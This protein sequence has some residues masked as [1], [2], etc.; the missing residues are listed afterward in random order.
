MLQVPSR[1]YSHIRLVV[2]AEQAS[3]LE[4]IAAGVGEGDVDT[5]PVLEAVVV[6]QLAVAVGIRIACI[7]DSVNHRTRVLQ[8]DN[9]SVGN[10]GII[11]AAIGIHN[12]TAQNLQVSLADIRQY[13][14]GSILINL[15]RSSIFCPYLPLA[16]LIFTGVLDRIVTIATSEELSDVC[17]LILLVRDAHKGIPGIV[18]IILAFCGTY[19]GQL[20]RDQVGRTDGSG[21]I[22]TAIRLVDNDIVGGVLT[23]DVQESASSHVC[24]TGTAI[25]IVQVAGMNGN[26]SAALRIACITAA[27]HIASNDN[28]RMG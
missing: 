22:V 4:C 1:T 24:L 7:C 25:H 2:A 16:R 23:V 3:Y 27:V 11:A 17:L 21:N 20:R 13:R 9:G 18:D 19:F 12:G 15:N 10:S 5:H 28:L 6:Q 8:G 26:R 14:L